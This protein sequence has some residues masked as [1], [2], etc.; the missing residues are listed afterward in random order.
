MAAPLLDMSIMMRETGPFNNG[1]LFL[2]MVEH[3]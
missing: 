1:P 3:N 2:T